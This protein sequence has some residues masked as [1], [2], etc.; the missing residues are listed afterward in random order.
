MAAVLALCET[1]ARKTFVQKQNCRGSVHRD[2]PN[3]HARSRRVWSF[4]QDVLESMHATCPTTFR[5]IRIFMRDKK[6]NL[7][8]PGSSL[9]VRSAE[10][11]QIC[12]RTALRT[13]NHF[14]WEL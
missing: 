14:F 6:K 3:A 13:T 5:R 10:E 9:R 2:F 1:K 11:V 8:K 12:W 7:T 4:T